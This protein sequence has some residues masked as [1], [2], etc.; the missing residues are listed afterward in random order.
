MLLCQPETSVAGGPLLEFYSC[1]LGLFR[2][3]SPVGC[4][5]LMLPAR[6]P[7]L[8][9]ASL[10]WSGEVVCEQVSMG[11]GHCTTARHASCCGGVGSSRCQLHARLW[12]D[13]MY[14]K[15]LLLWISVSAQG[16]H[17]GRKGLN[18]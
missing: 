2:P 3:L 13:Q 5:R 18:A 17:G 9:R 1:P 16:E 7:H 6:I 12:L 4:T 15:Q 10:A 11:P 14:H 8:P